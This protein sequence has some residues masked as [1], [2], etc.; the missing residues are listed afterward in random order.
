MAPGCPREL[1]DALRYGLACATT[2][3][4]FGV[5][6]VFNVFGVPRVAF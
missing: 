3:R 6:M 2:V 5:G 1:F 4:A